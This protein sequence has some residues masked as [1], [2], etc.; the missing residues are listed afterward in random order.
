MANLAQPWDGTPYFKRDRTHDAGTDD[1]VSIVRAMS[2]A[3]ANGYRLISLPAG[4]YTIKQTFVLPSSARIS[5][6]GSRIT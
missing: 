3:A 4:S 5:L 2:D 6:H 1:A